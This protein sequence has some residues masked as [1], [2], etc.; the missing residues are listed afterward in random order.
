MC[1]ASLTKGTNALWISLL[2]LSEKLN[3]FN[4]LIEEFDYSLK[5]S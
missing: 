5:E 1:Y 4:E 3:I 2:L